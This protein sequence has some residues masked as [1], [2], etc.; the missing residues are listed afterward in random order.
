MSS[1]P[2]AV[3][4]QDLAQDWTFGPAS[5]PA[6]VLEYADFE[7]PSC[8]RAFLELKRLE[9]AAGDQVR[10]VFRH[11]PLSAIHPR[12][13]LAAEAAE[14]AGAQGKFWEMHDQL[15]MNQR[16]LDLASMSAYAAEIGL[17]VARF[18]RDLE[19]HRHALKIRRDL[20]EG[21]RSGVNGT[22]TLFINGARWVDHATAAALLAGIQ[23]EAGATTGP[24]GPN[25]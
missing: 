1:R 20:M 11:F 4:T 6:T 14:A 10:F 15:F 12:A 25:V 23:R 8:R 18:T 13:M 22:P 17:D 19:E 21:E 7:C 3:F 24:W 16:A 5:A 9:F 2:R